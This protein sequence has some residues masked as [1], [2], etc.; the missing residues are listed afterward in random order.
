MLTAREAQTKTNNNNLL[1]YKKIIDYVDSAIQKS[2][3][4][5]EYFCEVEKFNKH[6]IHFLLC[7]LKNLGYECHCTTLWPN[8]ENISVTKYSLE[9]NWD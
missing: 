5:G 2:I 4:N 6:Q 7:F 3:S 1:L 8:K 9:I